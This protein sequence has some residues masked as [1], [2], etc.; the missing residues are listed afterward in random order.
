MAHNSW[1]HDLATQCQNMTMGIG[2]KVSHKDLRCGYFGNSNYVELFIT[3]LFKILTLHLSYVFF[4][5]I[6]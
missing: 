1:P 6:L 5:K 3:T 2:Y 4:N